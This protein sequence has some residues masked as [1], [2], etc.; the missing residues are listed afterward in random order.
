[1]I[2]SKYLQHSTNKCSHSHLLPF[3]ATV[4]PRAK[5]KKKNITQKKKNAK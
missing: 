4:I 5:K 2:P 3:R 1:M